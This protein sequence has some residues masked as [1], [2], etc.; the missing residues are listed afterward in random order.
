MAGDILWSG[1]KAAEANRLT[2]E[3]NSLASGSVSALSAEVDNSTN[4]YRFSDLHLVLASAAF[5]GSPAI[6][7]YLVPTVDGTNY[8]DFD[9]AA[10]PSIVNN[11]YYVGSIT[12]KPTTAAKRGVLRG[13]LLPPGKYK[14][15]LRNSTTVALAASGNT[16]AERQYTE[17]YT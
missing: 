3:L 14:W 15:A 7:V 13:V 11:N 2:T 17:A 10:S 16:L 1:Y 9:T 4:K 8:P 5:A 12:I 6:D